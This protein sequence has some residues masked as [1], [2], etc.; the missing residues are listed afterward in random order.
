MTLPG[1]GQGPFQGP[2]TG[3]ML[4][5]VLVSIA[6]KLGL[7]S[8][9]T[10]E[11]LS[12]RIN[13]HLL[14]NEARLS[15]DPIFQG[16]YTGRDGNQ[17]KGKNKTSADK[18]ADDVDAE[19]Q[20]DAGTTKSQKALLSKGFTTDATAQFV[21]LDSKAPPGKLQQV[22]D[23]DGDDSDSSLSSVPRSNPGDTLPAV[24]PIAK[25]PAVSVD[26]PLSTCS[27]CPHGEC[28]LIHLVV[29]VVYEN[30]NNATPNV[31]PCETYVSG[32][33]VVAETDDQGQ[34][35]FAARLTDM[36]PQSVPQ[37]SPIKKPGTTIWR[38]GLAAPE[39]RSK[40]GRLDDLADAHVL[41]SKIRLD[42]VDMYPL[43]KMKQPNLYAARLYWKDEGDSVGGSQAAATSLGE[44]HNTNT[45]S[46]IP[47]LQA[48][49]SL[50]AKKRTAAA[51]LDAKPSK[52]PEGFN[53]FLRDFLGVNEDTVLEM[54]APAENMRAVLDRVKLRA[55]CKKKIDDGGWKRCG[56]SQG[57]YQ[58]PDDPK[59]KEFAG[60]CFTLQDVWEALFM[61]KTL[62][63]N[64]NKLLD[65]N[66]LTNSRSAREWLEEPDGKWAFKFNSMTVVAFKRYIEGKNLKY[67]GPSSK[68]ITEVRAIL[69]HNQRRQPRQPRNT[70][71]LTG[72]AA[73]FQKEFTK[74]QHENERFYLRNAWLSRTSIT[75]KLLAD[76]DGLLEVLGIDID[77]PPT[78]FPKPL[79][80]LITPHLDC[81]RCTANGKPD[82]TLRKRDSPQVV[83]V[84]DDEFTWREAHLFTAQ[85]VTCHTD[86]YPDRMTFRSG[87]ERLQALEID[88]SYLRVSQHGIWM[89]RKVA[90]S[91]ER[92]VA[93]FHAGWSN[94]ATWVNETLHCKPQVTVRQSKRLFIEHFGRRLLASH[95]K[96]STFTCPANLKTDELAEYIRD[97]IGRNGGSIPWAMEHSCADCTHKKRYLQDLELEGVDLHG[98]GDGVVGQEGEEEQTVDLGE[99]SNNLPTNVPERPT[100]TAAPPEGSP[101]GYVRMAVM[102][103]KTVGHR[104]CSISTCTE[105]LQNFKDGRF[106]RNHIDMYKG[107]CGIIPCGRPVAP[108]TLTCDD[109]DHKQCGYSDDNK[110][111]EMRVQRPRMAPLSELKEVFLTW[112]AYLA[113]MWSIRSGRVLFIVSK[114]CSGHVVCQL[115]GVNAIVRR[116]LLKYWRFS[117]KSGREMNN[118]G[119]AILYTTTHVT[120]FATLSLRTHRTPGSTQPNSSSML[121]TTLDTGQVMHCVVFGVTL[122][123]WM[124]RSQ[125]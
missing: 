69:D 77:Q 21:R 60:Q 24:E 97:V 119:R 17:R 79:I 41:K 55:E 8:D 44:S 43:E 16:L 61:K 62:V 98:S 73:F 112:E 52:M 40:L 86:Y 102:D 18:V 51:A 5:G 25:Q 7:D 54:K 113:Q 93:R 3:R 42:V 110:R 47:L 59:Y 125:T 29:M 2:V 58:V 75:Q 71:W 87:D 12:E 120:S 108:G 20:Q 15:Q 124:V 36:I 99:A 37:A 33:P 105:P 123:Q 88:A 57:G 66:S 121:G 6:G 46:K 104:I 91:Q 39:N 70:A 4:K 116:V 76:L 53:P 28:Q 50:A 49:E 118:D 30:L 38:T 109:E 106:C 100:Q 96:G 34:V 31:P 10:R 95:G 1:T 35:H 107:I 22:Q 115:D 82:Q 19:K 64:D 122:P 89:H 14:A 9:G 63:S 90:L 72:A 81:I 26:N 92:A 103:G 45:G 48:R 23:V 114:R 11:V 74:S 56:S 68:K 27:P 84:L 67:E 80:I 83:R 78:L 32:V 65:A 13:A 85:C 111:P 117:I 94:Y 101:R